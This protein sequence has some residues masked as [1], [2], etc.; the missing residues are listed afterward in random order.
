M[1]FTNYFEIRTTVDL[2]KSQTHLARFGSPLNDK[3]KPRGKFNY[4][5]TVRPTWSTTHSQWRTRV[6]QMFIWVESPVYAK[7]SPASQYYFANIDDFEVS[8]RLYNHRLRTF[9][10]VCGKPAV[11][12]KVEIRSQEF[13]T[14]F[15]L[16]PNF[17]KRSCL[18]IRSI[19]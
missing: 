15:A 18:D 10:L 3:Y 17:I 7:T 6:F 19:R 5:I 14:V 2:I 16:F 9:L 13:L 12:L 8:P 11:N 4:K 1:E